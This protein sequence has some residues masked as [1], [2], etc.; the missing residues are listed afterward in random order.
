[1]MGIT[2]CMPIVNQTGSEEPKFYGAI[3]IDSEVND[4]LSKYFPLNVATTASLLFKPDEKY[5]QATYQLYFLGNDVIY[6]TVREHFIDESSFY[7]DVL[8]N[9]NSSADLPEGKEI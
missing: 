9:F 6:D 1:M 3:C 7:T 4:K 5:E 8:K 2:P